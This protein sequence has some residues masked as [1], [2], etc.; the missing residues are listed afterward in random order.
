MTTQRPFVWE[1]LVEG[2]QQVAHL[3]GFPVA[4][5]IAWRNLTGLLLVERRR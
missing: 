1:P 5:L 4:Y 2:V 3:G